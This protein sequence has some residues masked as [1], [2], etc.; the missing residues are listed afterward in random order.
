MPTILVADDNSNIQKMVAL[1]FKD[2]GIDVVTVGNGEAAIR[3]AVEVTPDIVLA[4]IFMPVR[5][6]YEVCEYLKQTTRFAHIPVILLAGAFDP[7]DEREAQRVGADGVL[8]K[9]FVPTDPLVNLVKGLL[10]KSSSSV[11]VSVATPAQSATSFEGKPASAAPVAPHHSEKPPAASITPE[12]SSEMDEEPV[13]QDFSLTPSQLG[14]GKEGGSDPFAD[15]LARHAEKDAEPLFQPSFQK[16]L[17]QQETAEATD[18]LPSWMTNP[19]AAEQTVPSIEDVGFVQKSP[20]LNPQEKQLGGRGWHIE[21]AGSSNP[22][23]ETI[24]EPLDRFVS[25]HLSEPVQPVP[26]G[27]SNSVFAPP[28]PPVTAFS[29]ESADDEIHVQTPKPANSLI[30]TD[31]LTSSVKPASSITDWQPTFPAAPPQGAQILDPAEEPVPSWRSFTPVAGPPSHPVIEEVHEPVAASEE[32]HGAQEQNIAKES[33]DI[34]GINVTTESN[35]TELQ[36]APQLETR[37]EPAA[38]SHTLAD[39]VPN[40]VVQDQPVADFAPTHSVED[41][42]EENRAPE[43][44]L[45]ANQWKELEAATVE[46]ARANLKVDEISTA[47]DNSVAVPAASPMDTKAVED[48][49]TRVVERMQPKILEVITREVLR[50]LVEALVRRQLEEK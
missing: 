10:A 43:A 34:E 20:P 6:G 21:P 18:N 4:D 31:E 37:H 25:Q 45:D 42:K 29:I 14:S 33:G 13:V 15:M 35:F 5:S 38:E 17:P 11:L 23:E 49:V 32:S 50:P 28:P 22:E 2:E 36:A 48:M 27:K 1:A 46:V 9:P 30:E 44:I 41:H 39:A 26:Q 8:K 12:F 3:K 16:D 19:P 47:Q 7:F 40:P 24:V